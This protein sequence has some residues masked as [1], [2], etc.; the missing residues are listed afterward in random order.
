M[1]SRFM[2]VVVKGDSMWPTLNDGDMIQCEEYASQEIS[3]S[4]IVVFTH[5][6]KHAVTCVKRVKRIEGDQLFVQGDNPDPTASDDS[7]NFGWI[8]RT[9]ILAIERTND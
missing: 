7:H 9:S 8:A 3:I 1:D 4:S 5:P 6:F 2:K